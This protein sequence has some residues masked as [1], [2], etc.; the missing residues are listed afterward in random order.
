M[1][2]LDGQAIDPGAGQ[3]VRALTPD[4]IAEALELHADGWRKADLAERYGVDAKTIGR[5]VRTRSRRSYRRRPSRTRRPSRAG[6]AVGDVAGTRR[7]P[8]RVEVFRGSAS[9]PGPAPP[10]RA[11][12]TRRPASSPRERPSLRFPT[13]GEP[14]RQPGD[15]I[16]WA[17]LA[18]GGHRLIGVHFCTR[19][20][21]NM[22][23]C[24][25]AYKEDSR[26]RTG[27]IS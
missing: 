3:S 12:M 7:G 25:T 16:R 24:S 9:D 4:Q 14:T 22:M 18:R 10:Q 20:R 1:L 13:G 2:G 11:G 8:R 23:S 6:P 26:A 5:I 21:G 17:I 19:H 27:G 15:G